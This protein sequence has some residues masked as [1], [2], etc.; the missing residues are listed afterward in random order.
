MRRWTIFT[1]ILCLMLALTAGVTFAQDATAE[2]TAMATAEACTG[3]TDVSV[4]LQWVTQAQFAGYYAAEAMGYYKDLCLTVKIVPGG[5]D[6]SADQLVASGE[7]TFGVR[8]FV[9]TLSAREGGADFVSLARVIQVP[10]TLIVSFKSSGI[11][12]PEDLKGKN[13]GSW[14]G[15]NEPEEFAF[16]RKAGIDPDKDVTI[17]KQGFDMSQ[18][19]NGEVVAAQATI[20]NEF[21]QLLE[22]TNP[23]TGKLYT[24]DELNVFAVRDYGINTLQDNI[25]ASG[26]WL[27]DGSN[28]DVA[29]RFVEA[30]LKGWIYCRDNGDKCVDIVLSQGTALGKGHQA[31]MMNEINGLIW[32]APNGIG[33]LNDPN[34]L[35]DTIDTAKT[36]KLIS[37]DP[38]PAVFNTDIVAQAVADLEAQGIDVKGADFKKQVVTPTAGG[39]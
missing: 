26:K 28:S 16:L 3:N 18:L 12:K 25:F 34:A 23:D 19:I 31:W 11:T 5:P 27:A 35:K 17:V 13:V 6:I 33:I 15:G 30:S 10:P 38:D 20:Y 37:K 8:P 21:A 9:T 7:V 29:R 22:T 14:L 24:P 32:P 4:A 2:A 1:G 36:Y 39:E